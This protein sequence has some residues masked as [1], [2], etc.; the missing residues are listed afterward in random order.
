MKQPVL[1][2]SYVPNYNRQGYDIA[3]TLRDLGYPVRLYQ[4]DGITDKHNGVI[5]VPCVKPMGRFHKLSMLRNLM[6]FVFR[7]LFV[8]K[9]TIICVGEPMLSLGGFYSVIF[10][11]K[12]IWYSLEYSQ[13]GVIERLVYKKCVSGYIDVEEN[14]RDAVFS[15]YGAK[16]V[17][18]VCYNMPHLHKTPVSGG[19]LR[20][21]L[22]EKH[23]FSGNEQLVVYAGSYQKYACLENIVRASVNFHTDMKLVLM[24]YGLPGG[25]CAESNNCIV[26]PPVTG[27]EFYNWLADADCALLPYETDHD[28]NVMNCSPQKIFDCYCV[29]VPYVASNRPI[30]N[31][32]LAVDASVGEVCDFNNP[33]D[34][35]SKIQMVSDRK[36]VVHEVMRQIH[37]NKLNYDVMRIE[38]KRMMEDVG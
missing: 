30:V 26:V 28:F 9:S 14:R 36:A 24:A 8:R 20:R 29:G 37:I 18:L 17:S 23:G 4:K 27:E 2:I 32:I 31:K 5:G 35:C 6:A 1:I 7:T 38:F 11:A 22:A 10:G 21:Y 34:I 33:N 12:L 25:I 13:L 3:D 16:A 19:A 15:Q